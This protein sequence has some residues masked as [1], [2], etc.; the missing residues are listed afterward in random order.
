MPIDN[1]EDKLDYIVTEV[2]SPNYNLDDFADFI[3][4]KNDGANLCQFLEY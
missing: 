4:E 2:I 3:G 1:I